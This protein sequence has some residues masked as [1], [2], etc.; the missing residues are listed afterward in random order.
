MRGGLQ[1]LLWFA[2]LL[3]LNSSVFFFSPTNNFS[4]SNTEF[5]EIY[6]HLHS[7]GSLFCIPMRE[8]SHLASF[9]SRNF[10]TRSLRSENSEVASCNVS[11][12]TPWNDIPRGHSQRNRK[13]TFT[14]NSIPEILSLAGAVEWP[15]SVCTIGA[16]LGTII[17]IQSTLVNIWKQQKDIDKRP[18]EM[19]NTKRLH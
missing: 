4:L 5:R 2:L 8:T 18:G 7:H 13:Q 11:K 6:V 16:T 19:D 12:E 15:H 9:S 17:M 10:S 1:R 3:K 14:F